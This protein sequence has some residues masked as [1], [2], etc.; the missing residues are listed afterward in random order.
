M[1]VRSSLLARY[2]ALKVRHLTGIDEKLVR[3]KAH[4]IR[5]AFQRWLPST[6]GRPFFAFLN[7]QDAHAPYLPPSEFEDRFGPKRTGRA[8]QDLSERRD[9]SE[10]ELRAERAAYDG[11]IGYVDSQIG[12]L[13][14]DLGNQGLLDNTIVIVS[15]DHGELFGEHGITD[16]GNSLYVPLLQVPLLIIYPPAIP[17]DARIETPVSLRDIAATIL[18]LSGNDEGL[19][20]GESLRG[21]WD[22]GRDW[23]PSPS[24]A[25]VSGGVRMPDWLPVMKGD[26]ASLFAGNFHYIRNGDGREELY[27]L[28]TDPDELTDL[29]AS[30]DHRPVLEQMRAS[31]AED[32][33]EARL[34][35]DVNR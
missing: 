35:A 5:E 8:L 27:D 31:L 28:S 18:D 17:A 13:L 22:D 3:V 21:A 10:D 30:P 4:S 12:Q 24:R 29:S 11:S 34:P 6:T 15:S 20:P 16:H 26:M 9:W 2:L 23:S 32:L 14:D 25:E 1:I 19:L 7:F 33:S